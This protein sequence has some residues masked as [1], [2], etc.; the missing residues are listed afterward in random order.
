MEWQAWVHCP[1]SSYQSAVCCKCMSSQTTADRHCARC[2]RLTISPTPGCPQSLCNMFSVTPADGLVSPNDKQLPV[3]IC[4]LPTRE[5]TIKDQSIL[6]CQVI[7]PRR[8]SVAGG[9]LTES[10]QSAPSI[11]DAIATI[12]IRVS[13]QSSYSRHAVQFWKVYRYKFTAV[14]VRPR[15]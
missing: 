7:E 2:C 12:P 8:S 9:S 3:Q 6:Q 11:G 13:C 1:A 10:L 15:I 5:L 4:V 14:L